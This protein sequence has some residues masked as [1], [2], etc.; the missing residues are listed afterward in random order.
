MKIKHAIL[1]IKKNEKL[2]RINQFFLN[3]FNCHQSSINNNTRQE[4][5]L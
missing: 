2:T 1:Q 3:P 5:K 4:K